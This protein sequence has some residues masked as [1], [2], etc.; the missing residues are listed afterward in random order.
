M[1]TFKAVDERAQ[2]AEFGVQG[3]SP[4]AGEGDPRSGASAG[5]SLLQGDQA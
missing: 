1:R 5:V 4:I 3:P 2:S